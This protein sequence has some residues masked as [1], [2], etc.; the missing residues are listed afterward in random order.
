MWIYQSA[1]AD[2][3]KTQMSLRSHCC[4]LCVEVYVQLLHF[5]QSLCLS[6]TEV[7]SRIFCCQA[8]DL[9]V[10]SAARNIFSH[11]ETA[12]EGAGIGSRV[13]TCIHPPN[14]LQSFPWPLS[15]PVNIVACHVKPWYGTGHLHCLSRSFHFRLRLVQ[16]DFTPNS[17]KQRKC[18]D[19]PTNL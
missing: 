5:L 18:D 12:L 3:E 17:C 15:D 6:S 2:G 7:N 16:F 4:L 8:S 9:E 11:G 1:F 10:L 13:W 14:P 19:Y